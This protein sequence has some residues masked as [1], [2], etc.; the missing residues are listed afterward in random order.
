MRKI[1]QQ[2]VVISAALGGSVLPV[3]AQVTSSEHAARRAALA[4]RVETG[5]VVAFGGR[6]PVRHWPAFS[7]LPSFR[8]LTGFL[9]SD[10]A[11]VM[12]SREGQTTETLFVTRPDAL[13]ALYNGERLDVEDVSS[14]L[15]MPA[16]YAD[17]LT[18]YV[19]SVVSMGLPIYSIADIQASE[20][21]ASDSL[22]TGRMFM[23][24]LQAR[25][26]GLATQEIDSWV[27]QLRAKKSPSEIALL[28][29]AAEISSRAH[30]AA[31]QAIR[32]GIRESDIQAIM[33]STYRKLGAD[34]PG[35]SSIV[36]SGP[37]STVLHYPAG[38]R[39]LQSGEV[40]LMDVAAYYQGYSADITR[41]VPVDRTFSPDMRA[42]YTVVLDAQ[43][44]AEAAIAPGVSQSEPTL[45]AYEVLWRGLVDLGLIESVEATFDPP[46]GLCPEGLA[47][48]DGSCP[49]WFMYVY[50]GFFHGIGLDVHDPSQASDV[51]PNT[52][53]PG[54]V[55]TIEPAI[56][57]RHD[58]FDALPDTQ[59]NRSMIERVGAAAERYRNL[60]VRIED[61][62]VLTPDGLVRITDV[63]REIDE[64]EALRA[65]VISY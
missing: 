36:G 43:K 61:N 57:V 62:Y 12:V 1:L 59:R 39:E 14:M 24:R 5:V 22:T 50:H 2:L 55:F 19:D 35:Y 28:T 53:E 16:R 10:A 27:D 9:Q 52:Y 4:E 41:T 30:E 44:A 20:Y 29:K 15:G 26:P 45:A 34:S 63:P 23:R 47:Q 18:A 11:L 33:E 6:E 49:Q 48:A 51:R 3:L 32:P 40:V 37:N 54:D 17:E 25:H 42:V 31:M 58:V 60:G 7:Q 8:Y 56:Y 65:K 13:L 46:P 64:I 21:S 38:T